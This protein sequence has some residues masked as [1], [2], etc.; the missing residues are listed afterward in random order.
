MN[1]ILST[2]LKDNIDDKEKNHQYYVEVFTFI[3]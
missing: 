2:K 3:I 1:Q